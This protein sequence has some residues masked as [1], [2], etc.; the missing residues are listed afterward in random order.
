MDYH[1]VIWTRRPE[2]PVKMGDLVVTPR[3]TRFSYTEEYLELGPAAAGLALLSSQRLYG[4]N[5]VIF[6]ARDAMP[7]HP[8]LM[9]LIP[10]EGR[11]N[12]QRRIY[13][14]ILE[15]RPNPPATGF[16]MDWELLLLTGHDG[17]GHLDLF[18][19]DRTAEASYTRAAIMA[20][21]PGNRSRF[22][23]AIRDDVA[24]DVELMDAEAV[25]ELLGPTPSAGGMIPKLLVAI[26]DAPEW[27]GTFA[28]PGTPEVEGRRFVEVVL[29]IEPSEYRG[30]AELE[31]L[32]LELHREV[33][34]D[35][36]RS[37]RATLDGLE[38]LAV[39]RFDF[40]AEGLPIPMESLFSVFATGRRDFN[41]NQDTDLAEVGVWLEKLAS[42]VNMDVR[43]VQR[44]M[45][46]RLCMAVC[47]GNGDMHLQN[48][49][50]LGGPE[51]VRLSPVYDPAPMRAWPQ[52]D[53]RLAVPLD[54]DDAIGGFG[55]NLVELGTKYGLTR[56]QAGEVLRWS[57]EV[58][59][60]YAERVQ[61]L[62]AVPEERRH[63]LVTT[64][65][66]ER[67]NL[68]TALSGG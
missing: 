21:T 37:W 19:D 53:V 42:V 36:P 15:K 6:Q 43:A 10:G 11:R 46:R 54:F 17:I 39:E 7:L 3:E 4:R 60:D 64:V 16:E 40:T 22:W 57:L 27:D 23:K 35:V 44:E 50:F 5:P 32:C 52:H 28:R 51:E 13:S 8:R 38:L 33:G 65:Q 34:F 41:S 61:G 56:K 30:V 31:A 49:S 14:R 9:A 62:N 18:R 24:L 63:R 47:T 12:I 55:E 20:P 45:Y 26:P 48:L 66:R 1:A 58:T 59:D 67:D 68:R 25:A 29:K 2:G